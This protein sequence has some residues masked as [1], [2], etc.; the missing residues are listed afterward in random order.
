MF[1]NE[2]DFK[3]IVERL[4]INDKPN[5]VHRDNLRRQMLS[6]FNELQQETLPHATT[7]QSVWRMIMKSRITKLAAAVIIIAVMIG[8]NYFGGSIDV[9]SIAWGDVVKHIRTFRPYKYMMATEYDDGRSA[10]SQEVMYL[11]P[12]QRRQ[13]HSDGT[14]H[15]VDLAQPKV[16][17]LVPKRK[18]A[19]ERTLDAPPTH[20]F[21]LMRLVSTLVK[22]DVGEIGTQEIDGHIAKGFHF[23]NKYNDVTIWADVE[24]KL[25]VRVEFIHVG[26]G[27]KI[28]LTNFEFKVNFDASLFSTTAP[29]GYTVEKVGKDEITELEKF[30]LTT[31]EEDLVEGLR[32]VVI[33][34]GGKFPPSIE[35]RELQKTLRQY[36]KQ[37]NLSEPEV[38][39]RL[40]PVSEKWTKA[41]WY[42]KML[43]G[44][45]Q[46][47]NFNYVGEGVNLNDANTPV[48]WWQPK[49][50]ETFRVIY[51]DLSVK[52]VAQENLLE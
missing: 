27:K 45:R 30:M 28:I 47:R 12:T 33:F 21:N 49:G 43:R 31:T 25:P 6:T 48:L 37:N 39:G 19:L 17:T 46:V 35:L 2:K 16:L 40:K 36:V 9:S 38:Q 8:I 5:D 52:D 51:G 41:H 7:W 20:D 3:E 24:T 32:A 42:T 4:D 29:K 18:Y 14:I 13:I 26:K 34:L 23:S 1:E 44:R 15:V 22:E 11:S 50:S 10:G